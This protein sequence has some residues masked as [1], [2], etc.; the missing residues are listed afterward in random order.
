VEGGS[1]NGLPISINLN[2]VRCKRR[3]EIGGLRCMLHEF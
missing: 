1:Y 2:N 3:G